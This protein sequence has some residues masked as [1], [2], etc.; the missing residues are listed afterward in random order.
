VEDVVVTFERIL[1]TLE[2]CR[3]VF[4]AEGGSSAS[5]VGQLSCSSRELR[6]KAIFYLGF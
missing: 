6:L 3:D 2:V 1:R 4:W 5:S